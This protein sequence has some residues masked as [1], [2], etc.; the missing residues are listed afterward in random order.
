MIRHFF[1]RLPDGFALAILLLPTGVMPSTLLT[2]LVFPFIL[3]TFLSPGLRAAQLGTVTLTSL[4]AATDK[5]NLAAQRAERT[6]ENE[7]LGDDHVP[8][9]QN[10][11]DKGRRSVRAFSRVGWRSFFGGLCLD[12]TPIVVSD[13][14]FSSSLEATSLCHIAMVSLLRPPHSRKTKSR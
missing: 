6:S 7:R 2:L 4:A 13:R 8:L 5:E 9:C 10:V 1:H 11:L 14:G 12:Q 3:A